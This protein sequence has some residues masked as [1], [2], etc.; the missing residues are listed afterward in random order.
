MRAV[1]T[2][3]MH[4]S[5]AREPQVTKFLN[6][7]K[8][9]K[10]DLL[11]VTGDT[12]EARTVF[13]NLKRY[14]DH[15]GGELFFVLGNHDYYGSSIK[16]VR[17]DARAFKDGLW[18]GR[19][20]CVQLT[21]TAFMVGVDGW[22]DARAGNVYKSPIALNDWRHIEEMHPAWGN[23]HKRANILRALGDADAADLSRQLATVPDCE[24]LVVLTHVPPMAD[25]CWY[26]GKKSE[27]DWL[28]W[29]SCIAVGDV[30]LDY[31]KAHPTQKIMVLCGHT[32]G[33]G[34]YQALPNLEVRTGGWA[35]GV[36]GYG[37]PRIQGTF[38]F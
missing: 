2:T 35:P 14:K 12:A 24:Q 31:A 23:P 7:V 21:E 9:E 36:E 22:G 3:D 38:E 37:N 33:E 6:S 17:D 26:N 5:H 8:A 27:P 20:D 25:A 28:P 19:T 1:W 32:H 34:V 10:P 15:V 16:A 18:L 30:L 4:L 29:F 13:R 11:F